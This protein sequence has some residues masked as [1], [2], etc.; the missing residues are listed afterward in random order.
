MPTYFRPVLICKVAM[1][2]Q[3]W[4]CQTESRA[5]R[6]ILGQRFEQKKKKMIIF[7]DNACYYRVQTKCIS[8]SDFK[9]RDLFY[10]SDGALGCTL[11]Y[12][13]HAWRPRGMKNYYYN[14]FK[15]ARVQQK[16]NEHNM[17]IGEINGAR[18]N[19]LV[20]QPR[21]SQSCWCL[22]EVALLTI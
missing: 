1:V 19:R 8:K 13:T 16:L 7:H 4:Y 10:T 2:I 18:R 22:N 21:T 9:R 12:F 3:R 11:Q 20:M 14:K 6:F 17:L 15:S 5:N